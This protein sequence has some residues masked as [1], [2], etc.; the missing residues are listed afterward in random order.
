MGTV[1]CGARERARWRDLWD[2]VAARARGCSEGLRD[3]GI[4][5]TTVQTL[6]L[7]TKS[8]NNL[9]EQSGSV[10]R[11]VSSE[12]SADDEDTYGYG[13]AKFSQRA[14]CRIALQDVRLFNCDRHGGNMLVRPPSEDD[15]EG[16]FDLVR[17]G[18]SMEEKGGGGWGD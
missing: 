12:G 7:R 16:G 6:L 14:A 9:V 8:G 15:P 4:P 1:A 2:S 3:A 5:P 11:F 17:F 18:R 13:G 10:Q